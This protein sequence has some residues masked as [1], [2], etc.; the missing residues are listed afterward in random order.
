MPSLTVISSKI[1]RIAASMGK[2]F[3]CNGLEFFTR[4]PAFS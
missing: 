3:Y 1:G 4:L 2:S